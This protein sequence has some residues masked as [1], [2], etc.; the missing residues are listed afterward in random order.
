MEGVS[1]T[2]LNGPVHNPY[3]KGYNAGGS[4]SGCARLVAT[5]EAD[6]AVGCDQGGSVRLPASACG[7]V[8]HKPTW[9]LVPYTG[10]LG[11][12][13]T[14]DHA[15]PMTRTVRDCAL[16]LEVIA[17]PDGW[18]D[19]QAPVEIIGREQLE[20]VR[21]VDAVTALPRNAMLE[22][23]RV[24][25]LSEGF[26]IPGHDPRVSE[27]VRSAAAKLSELGATVS[28]VSVPQHL[29]AT[30]AWMCAIPAATPR[31]SLLGDR[32]GR[33]ELYMTDRYDL[34]GDRLTQAQF[35]ALGPGASYMY[36]TYLW[37]QERYG[38]KLYARCMNLL[39]AAGV[40]K[41]SPF[42]PPAP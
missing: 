27:S 22:G 42:L 40:R 1:C 15:G 29:E 16:L 25:V 10:V 19:R 33:K 34:V 32:Q 30:V 14:I 3:A 37:A 21:D 41:F 38:P 18:D 17:G 12:D 2:S 35:E 4:S 24:G 7:I 8:G 11:V 13:A 23:M 36:L 31:A 39:K 6:L 20:F 26:V 5:G 28:T 9:G